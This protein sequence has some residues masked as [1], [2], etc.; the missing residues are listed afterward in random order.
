MEILHFK[1]LGKPSVVGCNCSSARV[2]SNFNNTTVVLSCC[3]IVKLMEWFSVFSRYQKEMTG[4][5]FSPV[6]KRV[7]ENTPPGEQ[8]SSTTEWVASGDLS[9]IPSSRHNNRHQRSART[10]AA[11][12]DAVHAVNTDPLREPI[13]IA[14]SPGPISVITISSDSEEEEQQDRRSPDK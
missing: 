1:D 8:P 13:L 11:H 9:S 3:Y 2:V 5:H 6:K 4:N 10:D 12:T 7:K 14:D